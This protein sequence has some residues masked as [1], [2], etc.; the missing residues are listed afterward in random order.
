MLMLKNRLHK[1]LNI[2]I[3]T[4]SRFFKMP[5]ESVITKHRTIIILWKQKLLGL[6]GDT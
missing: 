4:Q 2:S 1:G 3:L 5:G 6:Q